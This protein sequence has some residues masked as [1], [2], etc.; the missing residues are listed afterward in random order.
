MQIERERIQTQAQL[1][2]TKTAAQVEQAK[3]K[4][5]MDIVKH[6]TTHAHEKDN[7]NKELFVKGL[8][9]AHK[10]ASIASQLEF[11]AA[12]PKPTKKDKGE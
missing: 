2:S 5:A 12:N 6:A 10:H 1:E 7:R 3:E 9:S 4:T 11:K 8:D